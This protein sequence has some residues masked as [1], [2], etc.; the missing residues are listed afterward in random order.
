MLAMSCQE[1]T[2]LFLA[3]KIKQKKLN[4]QVDISTFLK[5]K[6]MKCSRIQTH[7]Y[8]ALSYFRNRVLAISCVAFHFLARN[9]FYWQMQQIQLINGITCLTKLN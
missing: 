6:Q 7:F 8:T 3:S 4:N 1:L 2:Q 9:I 5:P